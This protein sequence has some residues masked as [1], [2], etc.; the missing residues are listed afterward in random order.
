MLSTTDIVHVEA[1]EAVDTASDGPVR[2]CVVTGKTGP[3]ESFLR[4]VEAPDGT[5]VPD[6]EGKLPGRG[7]WL[8]V[9]RDAV[10]QAVAR[11]AF[12]KAAKKNVKAAAELPAMVEKL[13]L[14]RAIESLSLAKRAGAIVAG[15]T[16]AKTAIERGGIGLV[17]EAL[18]ASRAERARL[19]GRDIPTVSALSAEE[20]GAALGRENAVHVAVRDGAMAQRLRN[21]L[22]RLAAFRTASE[23]KGE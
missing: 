6:I 8:T 3:R 9:S 12:A 17:V 22:M 18:D 10:E 20:M 19:G 4:F 16:K 15:F 7:L 11:N 2:R 21:D 5:V 1:S 14:R 13:L 23:D